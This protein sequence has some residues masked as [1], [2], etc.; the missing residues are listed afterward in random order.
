MKTALRS[1]LFALAALAAG[2]VFSQPKCENFACMMARAHEHLGQKKYEDALQAVRAARNYTDAD[3]R[4]ADAFLEDFFA[5]IDRLRQQADA[6]KTEAETQRAKAEIARLLAEEKGKA[7]RIK[8][9][10]LSRY[11]D[12]VKIFIQKSD[13][14]SRAFT[15]RDAYDH[16]RKLGEKHFEW[17][18]L[19]QKRDYEGA[20]A[21]FALARFFCPEDHVLHHT[22]AASQNGT[23]AET[24]FWAGRLDSAKHFYEA[25]ARDVDGSGSPF[26]VADFERKRLAEIAETEKVFA[27]FLQK[28][29]PAQTV[30]AVLE[31]NWWTVPAAFGGFQKLETLEIRGWPSNFDRFPSAFEGLQNLKKLTVADC[32]NLRNLPDWS[33]F[34][35]AEQVVLQGNSSLFAVHF[36][37]IAALR[38]LE[39]DACTAL[40][41]VDGSGDLTELRLKKSP[42][43]RASALLAANLALRSIEMADV[44]EAELNLGGFKNL[45][46]LN[47]AQLEVEKIEGLSSSDRLGSIDATNL[48]KVRSIE[49]PKNLRSIKISNCGLETLSLPPSEGLEKV[50]ILRAE[51]L[52]FLPHWSRYPNLRALHVYE[53]GKVRRAPRTKGLKNLEEVVLVNNTRIRTHSLSGGFGLD[54]DVQ[55]SSFKIEYEWRRSIGRTVGDIALRGSLVAASKRFHFDS[56]E[57]YVRSLGQ[58]AILAVTYYSPYRFY[59]S[60]GVGPGRF[61]RFRTNANAAPTGHTIW[62]N[63]LGYQLAPYFLRKD[64]LSVNMDL[65]TIFAKRPFSTDYNILPSLGLTYYKTLSMGRKTHFLR[66]SDGRRHFSTERK[67]FFINAGRKTVKEI[68]D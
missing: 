26:F 19:A 23:R 27:D 30:S 45:E 60:I 34:E 44:R 15:D 64:K 43:V 12:S 48:K 18:L 52:R 3:P 14:L 61:E 49:L 13:D 54:W 4:V 2:P 40:T 56:S 58:M 51:N 1:V 25:A 11:I 67:P 38:S 37:K 10:S 16:F 59:F 20:L 22:I 35:R 6:D 32:P 21:Y 17:D 46:S 63:S 47:L 66:P 42:H 50:S 65:Y 29:D 8:S 9:D 24:H 53:C 31:G 55:P 5:S 68:F 36:E 57:N 39:I 41:F 7:L 28:N 62:V 33:T